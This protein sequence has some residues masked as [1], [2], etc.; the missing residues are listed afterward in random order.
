MRFI[1]LLTATLL[2]FA[3]GA[4]TTAA[5]KG[6]AKGGKAGKADTTKAAPGEVTEI[7]GKTL[8]E[9]IKAIQS[10]DR[11]ESTTAIKVVLKF[12]P[13]QAR[14]A[15]PV[16][17]EELRKSKTRKIDASVLVNAP[18]AILTILS[19]QKDPPK[20]EIKEAIEL[21]TGLLNDPQIVIRYRAIESLVPFGPNARQAIPQLIK[22]TRDP[23][24]WETRQAATSALAAIA[25]P[26]EKEKAPP[27][28]VMQA[29]YARLSPTT[30]KASQV[31]LAAIESL[32]A[33]TAAESKKSLAY[34]TELDKATRDPKPLVRIA[35]QRALYDIKPNL[36]KIR[37]AAIA[38]LLTHKE[39]T[40]R[41]AAV[42]ALGQ[43]GADAKDRLPDLERAVADRDQTVGAAALFAIAEIG[44]AVPAARSFLSEL[45]QS[46]KA[47]LPVRVTAAQALGRVGPSA[48]DQRRMFS[49]LL[50]NSKQDLALRL[51]AVSALANIG[52]AA[53][54]QISVLLKHAE[55]K[56]LPLAV[57]S[58]LAVGSMGE[59]GQ[60]AVPSL[61]AIAANKA[62]PEQVRRAAT[63]VVEHFSNLKKGKKGATK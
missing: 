59:A 2:A 53:A 17:L 13:E 33:L 42:V 10:P 40:V 19:N 25:R 56:D 5:Q 52:A 30:E 55:D 9:W 61:Q 36:N 12:T 57:A 38:K 31:R 48:S 60:R 1:S 32:R 49:E 6:G 54:D 62:L 45:I 16:L 24:T 14:K 47:D 41:L 22:L 21:F 23:P 43:I 15:L 46:P 44:K 28:E 7:G 26:T 39:D 50:G 35:A 27:A 58:V 29:L 8:D 51:E 11:S 34:E 20:N 3:A 4:V 63:E 18:T 37:R